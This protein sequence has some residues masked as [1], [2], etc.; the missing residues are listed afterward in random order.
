MKKMMLF[1]LFPVGM[2][3]Q[4]VVTPNPFNI[5]SGTV[6]ITYGPDYSLFDPFSDP[7]LFL[8]TGLE[9]TGDSS[10]DHT[11]T[12]TNTSTLV[13][14]T[15]DSGQGKYVATVN[16]GTRTYTNNGAGD[17][18][19]LDN[20]VVNQW[21]FIIRN[22]AGDRQSPDLQGTNYGFQPS[23]FLSVKE[24]AFSKNEFK[25]VNGAFY[26]NIKGNSE[27]TIYNL[28][29]KK[30][31]NFR[32]NQGETKEISLAKNNLYIAVIN[33]GDRKGSVK[34]IN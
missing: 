34:F 23:T 19:L 24:N 33:N 16:I 1:L 20:T 9:T 18:T 6:T 15:Y 8:Y 22:G 17:T 10:W 31:S 27:V 29:G 3:A 12:W 11:D 26:S 30:I 7:N 13:P 2:F 4:L 21:F 14:L 28:L 5:N 25:V 32:I